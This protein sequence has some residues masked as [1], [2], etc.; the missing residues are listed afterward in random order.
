MN[1]TELVNS[2]RENIKNEPP[3]TFH[4]DGFQ[5]AA[6]L[7]PILLGPVG[8]EVL[9]TV[10]SLNLTNHPGQIAFPGGK[11]EQGE[12]VVNA[13]RRE[14]FEEI[15][16]NIECGSIVGRLDDI[17]SPA[18]YV[19]TPVVAI[20]QK[21]D[22]LK[23]NPGEVSEAFRIELKELLDAEPTVEIGQRFGRDREVFTYSVGK[24]K[25]WG[26]TASI[27][28]NLL[29]ILRTSHCL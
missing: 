4:V 12:G 21:E 2:L 6:V 29:R 22:V 27:L 19:A 15:G 14:T 20:H 3:K 24:R 25:I 28:H 13:A 23:L 18:G 11:V 16:L 17:S 10:R 9:F 8:L 26:F 1:K 5:R 7:V